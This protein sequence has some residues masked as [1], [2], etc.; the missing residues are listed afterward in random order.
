MNICLIGCGKMGSALL[1]GWQ[2]DNQLEASFTVIDPA[3][4]AT[5][6][7]SSTTYLHQLSELEESYNPDL[8]IPR[9]A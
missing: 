4:N 6:K 2:Q 5:R 9:S 3:I 1:A 8:V 7:D